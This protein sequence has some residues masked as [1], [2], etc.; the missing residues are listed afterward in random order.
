[1]RS[2]KCVACDT[3][4]H[5]TEHLF[6]FPRIVSIVILYAGLLMKTML[7]MTY[8]PSGISN[9]NR[10]T[11]V[12]IVFILQR[13]RYALRQSFTNSPHNLLDVLLC[14]ICVSLMQKPE[15]H[16]SY[17]P[18]RPSYSPQSQ[19]IIDSS[20]QQTTGQGHAAK[21]PLKVT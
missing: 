21:S 11:N 7:V 10:Y 16:N 14:I 15:T 9:S 12:L 4:N 1:M 18:L 2:H 19:T 20:C 3:G 17:F 8:W 5:G 13:S 6:S